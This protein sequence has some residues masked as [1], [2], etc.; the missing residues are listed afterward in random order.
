MG[1]EN[2]RSEQDRIASQVWRT[3][4][5]NEFDVEND[6]L[7]DLVIESADERFHYFYD[8][9]GRRLVKHFVLH[10]GPRVETLCTVKLIRKDEGY[11]PRLRVW[12]RNT[13]TGGSS[14]AEESTTVANVKAAVDLDDGHKNFWK[15]VQFLHPFSGVVLPSHEF[16]IA[17]AQDAQ[18]IE[19]FQGHE[20]AEVLSAVRT[21]LGS[22]LSEADVQMLVNRRRTLERFER[23]LH[24]PDF[25]AAELE[26][27][28][29]SGPEHAWQAFFEEN[30]WI[31]GY[32]LDLVSCEEFSKQSLE[33]RT[34]GNNVFTGG[35]KRVDAVMRTRGF[36][37]SLLFAEIKHPDT[38]LL[39][40]KPYR[41]PDVFRASSELS[42]AVAQ[43]QKTVHK[44]VREL[45][46]LHRQHSAG[47]EFEFEVSTIKPRQVV[48]IGNLSQLATGDNVNVEK[49][50]SF[51]LYRRSQQDV[52]IVTFDELY[53]RARYIVE[54]HESAG[55]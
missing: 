19:A 36:L 41:V 6:D 23:L 2:P 1:S 35:G 54:S 25:V 31:F 50:T 11:S 9:G 46:D 15:L 16:R 22:E 29:R 37:Q 32:G 47:G 10:R 51:E 21:Y 27:I 3:I 20:K 42:G 44:A 4:D 40:V 39:A 34:T 13:S 28:G 48:V 49:M 53:E 26:R 45:E 33:A 38:D 52:E 14:P 43:V 7:S 12:K 5:V 24:S 55:A 17:S 8:P 18:L 30:T